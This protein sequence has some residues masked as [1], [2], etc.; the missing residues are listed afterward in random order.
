MS[1]YLSPRQIEE[2]F[3]SSVH[4]ENDSAIQDDP[5]IRRM[6][7]WVATTG[8]DGFHYRM[9]RDVW[10]TSQPQIWQAEWI[11]ECMN[12]SYVNTGFVVIDTVTRGTP[13]LHHVE[14][15][16]EAMTYARDLSA[17][18]IRDR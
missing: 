3:G 5:A 7:D 18:I 1:S 13:F 10:P 4:M 15:F 16:E 12:V 2:G 11:D 6:A 8:M 17:S 14:T 9:P